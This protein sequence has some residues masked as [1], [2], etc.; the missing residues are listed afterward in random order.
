[1]A[2]DKRLLYMEG[3]DRPLAVRYNINRTLL[4]MWCLPR[5]QEAALGIL[6]DAWKMRRWV[7]LHV[8]A[9]RVLRVT[10]PVTVERWGIGCAALGTSLRAVKTFGRLCR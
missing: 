2:C 3:D 4:S 10:T 5:Q 7:I 1:M 6:S 9:S 8:P